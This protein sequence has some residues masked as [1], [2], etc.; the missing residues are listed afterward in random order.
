MNKPNIIHYIN[1]KLISNIKEK[2]NI[3]VN[4]IIKINVESDANCL[5]SCLALFVYKDETIH[6]RV[7]I[8]IYNY[9]IIYKEEY[10]NINFQTKKGILNIDQYI[11]YI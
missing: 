4:D 5:M 7:R 10:L 1:E 11:D 2:K 9:I 6:I 3:N 8:E